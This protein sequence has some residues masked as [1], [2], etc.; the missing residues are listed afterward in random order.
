MQNT[1]SHLELNQLPNLI[2]TPTY[3]AL[4]IACADSEITNV[5]TTWAEKVLYFRTK[6]AHHTLRD[7]YQNAYSF[8][9]NNIEN[10][11]AS[12]PSNQEERMQFISEKIIRVNENLKQVN[13]TTKERLID[14]FKSLALSVAEID[15]GIFNFF[16][17]N[18]DEEKW[19]HL[20]MIEH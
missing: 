14:S 13:E 1:I 20:P 3:V 4:L 16:A 19:L 15:G 8:Y 12:L 5:E 11:L 10:I 2:E 6:T 9:K 18:P 17:S 7:F